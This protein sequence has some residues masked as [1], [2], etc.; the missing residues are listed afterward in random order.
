MK[1]TKISVS[2]GRTVNTGNFNSLRLDASMEVDLEPGDTPPSAYAQAYE[3][4]K[5]IVADQVAKAS[6]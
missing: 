1:P 5:A 3:Q 6:K 4:V 2:F